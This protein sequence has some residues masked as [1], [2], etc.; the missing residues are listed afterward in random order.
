MGEQREFFSADEMGVPSADYSCYRR[1]IRDPHVCH[2]AFRLWHYLRDRASAKNGSRC[3]PGQRLIS[4]EMNCK[5]DSLAGWIQQLKTAGYLQTQSKGPSRQ[6]VYILQ[7]G[8]GVPVFG[9]RSGPQ[10]G[11]TPRSPKRT[12]QV[13]KGGPPSGPL[14]ETKS[15]PSTEVIPISEREGIPQ[16]EPV[17]RD[18][19]PR[20]YERLVAEATKELHAAKSNEGLRTRVLSREAAQSCTWL[21][22]AALGSPEDATKHLSRIAQLEANA[23]N[24]TSGPLSE[25]GQAVVKALEARIQAIKDA[26]NGRIR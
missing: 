15:N 11:A 19:F 2:G 24:W 4:R 8:R 25:H 7:D 20:D 16:F 10:P 12:C 18:L 6:T 13:P 3:W 9:V 21:R 23:E 17:R 5:R 14:P 22:Q 26:M 1:L